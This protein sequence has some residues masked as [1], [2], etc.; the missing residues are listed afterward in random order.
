MTT[1]ELVSM[2]CTKVRK[3]NSHLVQVNDCKQIISCEMKEV[4]TN[5]NNSDSDG[6]P[7]L[8]DMYDEDDNDYTAPEHVLVRQP[9]TRAK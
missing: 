8:I 2:T 6:M 7:D 3:S 1:A 4:D 9:L 5:A